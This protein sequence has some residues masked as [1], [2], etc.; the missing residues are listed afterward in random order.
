MTHALYIAWLF[1]Q[2]IGL[3]IA[4]AAVALFFAA[5][6]V[7]PPVLAGILIWRRHQRGLPCK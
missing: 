1:I 6:A 3:S 7:A 4:F 2:L 5:C